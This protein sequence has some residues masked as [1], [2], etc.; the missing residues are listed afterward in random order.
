MSWVPALQ[1]WYANEVVIALAAA[2]A[3]ENAAHSVRVL[4][5]NWAFG[6]WVKFKPRP[7]SVAAGMSQPA[8]GAIFSLRLAAAS[9]AAP[10]TIRSTTASIHTI[11]RRIRTPLRHARTATTAVRPA[12]G[13]RPTIPRTPA[14][15]HTRTP[16]ASAGADAGNSLDA[17]LPIGTRQRAR[18]G[19]TCAL[20]L[21]C[22]E[23]VV[24]AV[25]HHGQ[26]DRRA[27]GTATSGD[28]GVQSDL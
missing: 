15:R 1:Y 25:H 21:T 7:V 16:S 18:D 22:G 11:G 14:H 23:G 8:A 3:A 28:R 5:V 12:T 6:A 2:T 17:E 26:G 19:A 27:H 24:N 10:R 9:P 13:S 20:D 4:G